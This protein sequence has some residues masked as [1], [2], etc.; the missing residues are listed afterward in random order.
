VATTT[1]TTTTEV[2][3][4]PEVTLDA[5]ERSR[6]E[7]VKDYLSRFALAQVIAKQMRC[8]FHETFFDIFLTHF[9]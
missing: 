9:F 8:P 5:A 6:L 4:A 7:F 2:E 3:P 1:T